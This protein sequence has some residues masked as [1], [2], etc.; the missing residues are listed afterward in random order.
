MTDRPSPLDERRAADAEFERKRRRF[1]E[2]IAADMLAAH[3][4]MADWQRFRRQEPLAFLRAKLEIE[5]GPTGLWFGFEYD[6]QHD[7]TLLR[8]EW[9]AESGVVQGNWQLSS[10]EL[11]RDDNGDFLAFVASDTACAITRRSGVATRI[12]VRSDRAAYEHHERHKNDPPTARPVAGPPRTRIAGH[13]C[14]TCKARFR[15][16]ELVDRRSISPL[17][18]G[19]WAAGDFTERP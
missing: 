9:L 3:Y 4:G 2:Y 5:G 13:F 1:I 14:G 17:P 16:E 10:R 8:C 12:M 19:H 15:F 7:A 11:Q 18:C 6:P